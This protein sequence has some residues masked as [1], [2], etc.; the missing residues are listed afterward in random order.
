MRP[1]IMRNK[2]YSGVSGV[3]V[4]GGVLLDSITNCAAWFNAEII[5][6]GSTKVLWAPTF[7]LD[8]RVRDCPI[9][10]NKPTI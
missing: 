5:E 3:N 2:S 6:I 10:K 7:K 8:V 9:A 4:K 1:R